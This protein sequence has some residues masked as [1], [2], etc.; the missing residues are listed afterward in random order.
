MIAELLCVGSELLLGDILNT[1]ARFLSQELAALGFCVHRQSVVGDNPH[2]LRQAFLEAHSR[3][4]FVFLTGGLGPTADDITRETICD[5]LGFELEECAELLEKMRV[6][7]RAQGCVMPNTNAKQAFLP[8]GAV[9]YRDGKLTSPEKNLAYWFQNPN[10]TAP[11]IALLTQGK[12]AVMLPGPPSELET[13]YRHSLREFL[14]N[15]ADGAVISHEVRTMGIGESAM[16]ELV[17][18]L[19][20]GENP[21][22]APYA[23]N[24]ESFLRVTAKGKTAKDAEALMVPVLKEIK[25][26]LAP[27]IYG[28]DV[29]S[30]EAVLVDALTKNA[31]TVCT[32]ESITGGGIAK[33]LTD[34]QGASK[35]LRGSVVA[36]CDEVKAALLKVPREI[37]ETHGAVSE[38][39]A[40][41]M[42]QN[43]RRIFASEYSIAA[44]GNA[45]GENDL[46]AFV[47]IDSQSGT[48]TYCLEFPKGS[49]QRNR[50]ITENTALFQLFSHLLSITQGEK[51]RV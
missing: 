21:S 24:G 40:K 51:N 48:K 2:S 29:P 43:A 42:A 36:Y 35:V 12:C 25:T 6:F 3:A 46:R 30:I 44:T 7:F 20:E 28:V 9:L 26:R 50:L 11:A 27:F 39:C 16:A 45:D 13:I 47:A 5:A 14:S 33:R 15:W 37:L 23:K 1:N 49:R 4:D 41:V 8:R 38:E 17:E 31:Q 18:P 34:C 32:A 19:L 22:V 10:G